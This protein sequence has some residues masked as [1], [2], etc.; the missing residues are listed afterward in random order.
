MTYSNNSLKKRIFNYVKAR[1]PSFVHKG[2]LGR[3]A[4]SWGFENENMGRRCRELVKSGHFET[5]YE[6]GLNGTICVLYRYKSSIQVLRE[7][8]KLR[9]LQAALL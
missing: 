2:E 7:Q 3:A 8:E 4:I 6:K 9:I 1:Y 5:K